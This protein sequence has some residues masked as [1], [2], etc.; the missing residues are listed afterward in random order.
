[1]ESVAGLEEEIMM[2]SSRD[3]EEEDDEALATASHESVKGVARASQE[4]LEAEAKAKGYGKLYAAFG[5][6][7]EG[8]EACVAV[9]AL[10]EVREGNKDW[11][12]VYEWW[13]RPNAWSEKRQVCMDLLCGLFFW[14]WASSGSSTSSGYFFCLPFSSP[15]QCHRQAALGLH[16]SPSQSD[17]ISTTDPQGRSRVHCSLNINTETGR[18]SA[19]RPNLQNQPA[20]EKDRY[21]ARDEGRRGQQSYRGWIHNLM[22]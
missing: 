7:L 22:S 18:L 1:M 11:R 10:C 6:G 21:K 9:E 19:R 16:H 5:G 2:A 13:E 17:D 8:L 14:A 4:E 3:E 20:L 15:G 12:Q